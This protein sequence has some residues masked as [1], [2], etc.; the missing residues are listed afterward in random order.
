MQLKELHGRSAFWPVYDDALKE[1]NGWLSYVM[2]IAIA[3]I[4][5]TTGVTLEMR[6]VRHPGTK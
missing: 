2:A 1:A 5:D 6:F 3:Q 4:D